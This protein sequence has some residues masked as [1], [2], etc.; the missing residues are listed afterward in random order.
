MKNF[1][2]FPFDKHGENKNTNG[3]SNNGSKNNHSSTGFL[4]GSKRGKILLKN[5]NIVKNGENIFLRSITESGENKKENIKNLDS[6][7]DT[8]QEENIV[9]T[10]TKILQDGDKKPAY[11]IMNEGDKKFVYFAYKVSA[12]FQKISPERYHIW[13]KDLLR[14]L[15]IYPGH[16]RIFRI[17]HREKKQTNVVYL[18][19]IEMAGS[20]I[21]DA[22]LIMEDWHALFPQINEKSA[23][24]RVIFEPVG[25]K[26]ALSQYAGWVSHKNFE[27]IYRFDFPVVKVDKNHVEVKGFRVDNR[28]NEEATDGLSFAGELKAQNRPADELFRFVALEKEPSVLLTVIRKQVLSAGMKEKIGGNLESVSG[29]SKLYNE[30]LSSTKHFRIRHYW[31]SNARISRGF[32][33]KWASVVLDEHAEFKEVDFMEPD[34]EPDM[35][36]F[37]DLVDL[38]TF[39]LIWHPLEVLAQNK[40]TG[41]DLITLSEGNLPE[42]MKNPAGVKIGLHRKRS[43][44]LS[45]EILNKHVYMIGQTGSGK[46]S[47][48]YTMLKDLAEKGAGFAY[49]DPHGD[50]YELLKKNLPEKRKKDIILFD[51][52][53]GDYFNLGMLDYDK[54]FPEHKSFIINEF[55]S[56]FSQ[57]YD[58]KHVAGPMF[59]LYFKNAMKLVMTCV[60]DPVLSDVHEVFYDDVFREELLRKCR[61]NE[62]CYS[63][64]KFFRKSLI[65]TGESSFENFAP[66]IT[67]KLNHFTDNYY[68]EKFVTR[69]GKGFNFREAMDNGKI[70]LI[71]LNKGRMGNLAV[72]LTGRLLVHKF[73]LAAY[74]RS[75]IPREDRK[76]FYVLIDE[77]QNFTSEEI[78]EAFAEMRKFNLRLILANQT[79]SQLKEA[80]ARNILAN[81]GTLMVSRISPF[82]AGLLEPVFFPQYSEEDLVHLAPFKF[83]V[84]TSSAGR[85]VSPFMIETIPYER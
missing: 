36:R 21:R 25:Q 64:F 53:S 49:I 10:E 74:T 5:K 63:V 17:L 3:K 26:K 73:I 50:I 65:Q 1:Q 70:I 69:R 55:L 82:D 37:S 12:V 83:V 19:K 22:G 59:E 18:L 15:W 6:V 76:P 46:S 77:F 52:V 35:K 11:A 47:I 23:E 28:G 67:S 85:D 51:P 41:Y 40:F 81:A 45:D 30:I 14:L 57:L 31:M 27:N 42:I 56:F 7:I 39:E 20:H 24:H 48:I 13:Q 34:E 84:K 2:S 4:H 66:Y 58:M 43:V 9:S 44:Y 8:G 71:K 68:L 75:D 61:K 38:R 62:D 78:H 16:S 72:S 60:D 33:L 79:L 32:L 29:F 80:T 54:R